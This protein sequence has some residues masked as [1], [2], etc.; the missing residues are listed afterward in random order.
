MKVLVATFLSLLSVGVVHAESTDAKGSIELVYEPIDCVK[1][2]CPQFKVVSINGDAQGSG[3]VGEFVDF[4]TKGFP[5]QIPVIVIGQWS[6]E[7]NYFKVS[8]KEWIVAHRK[9]NR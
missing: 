4:D 1:A 6:Q 5:T 2:P 7:G 8:V 3:L 9:S